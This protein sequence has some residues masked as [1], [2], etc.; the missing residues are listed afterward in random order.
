MAQACI[1]Y[2]QKVARLAQCTVD[3]KILRRVKG[4]RVIHSEGEASE[5]STVRDKI[6]RRTRILETILFVMLSIGLESGS[7]CISFSNN[8]IL[9]SLVLGMES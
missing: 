5:R 2:G 1:I 9:S 8:F 7:D 6:D 4:D 3:G